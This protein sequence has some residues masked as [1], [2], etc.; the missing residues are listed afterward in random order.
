MS[1]LY[2]AYGSNLNLEQMEKRSPFAKHVAKT[3]LENTSIVYQGDD[4][5]IWATLVE[6]PG[7]HVPV[8]IW[9]ITENDEAILDAYEMV[10]FMYYKDNIEMDVNGEKRD[11]LIYLMQ[12]GFT[13]GLPNDPYFKGIQEGYCD[14]G[15][16]LNILDYSIALTLDC[17][18]NDLRKK[19]KR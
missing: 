13:F 14:Q 5:K 3:T 9:E 15:F 6:D 2:C 4:A 7:H 12:E 8:V 10:P 19:R 17:M 1:K 18:R 11:V 16:D